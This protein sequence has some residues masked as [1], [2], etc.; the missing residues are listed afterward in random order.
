V[1]N[2]W[3]ALVDGSDPAECSRTLRQAH[4][5]FATSGQVSVRLRPVVADSWRRCAHAGVDPEGAA[6]PVTLAGEE[7]AAYRDSHP[8][9]PVLPLLR[10]LL[11]GIA[12]D[13]RHVMAVCD[14]VGRLLWVEGEPA[15]VGQAA[16]INF[17]EG[18]WWDEQH[19]GTNAPAVA[20]AVDHAVQIFA[21]EHF[22][23][24]VQP[25]TC[26]AAP[27]HDPVTG[28]ILGAVDLTG[29]D[30]LATPHALALVQA[31][32]QV[33]EAELA[34]LPAQPRPSAR[35]PLQLRVLG[36]DEG[37]LTG[38]GRR[39]RLSR[40]HS[41]MLVI[42]LGHPEG[43]GGDRLGFET[44]GEAANPVTLRAEISRLRTVLGSHL[45]GSRPYR[46]Q[47]PLDADF[48]TVS[49]LLDEG[50]LRAALAAYRG[51][52]LPQSQAPGIERV[53][54]VLDA[55]LRA[56][57]AASADAAVIGAWTEAPWGQE[58][59]EMWEALALSLPRSSP[60]RPL[61]VARAR[62]LA[63]ELAAPARARRNVA[64]GLQRSAT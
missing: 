60:R 54:H 9:A 32:A 15:L 64:T 61:A 28:Q 4:E 47:V 27:I 17:V 12:E 52:L 59:A 23:L 55:A 20:L 56:A 48:T 40:R 16:Q 6:P 37:L 25:W 57:V 51:P 26:C 10:E 7:L 45:L 42:L 63:A 29:G 11:G 31:A 24:L 19:A 43:V 13:G 39:L 36:C 46:L 21:A 14:A 22:S 33:A 58:D 50:D 62:D 34:R 53:R 18:A 49:R 30:H 44:Y 2:P 38:A 8:L 5:A 41:E 35:R 1:H 3:L